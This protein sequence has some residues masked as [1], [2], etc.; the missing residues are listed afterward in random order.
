MFFTFDNI[1][2][3]AIKIIKYFYIIFLKIVDYII[4]Q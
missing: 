4:A 2:I 1:I 3:L